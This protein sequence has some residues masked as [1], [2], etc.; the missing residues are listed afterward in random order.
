MQ[1]GWVVPNISHLTFGGKENTSHLTF[2]GKENT[3]SFSTRI[4]LVALTLDLVFDLNGATVI[5]PLDMIGMRV[6]HVW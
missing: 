6:L 4:W 5:K 2:G 1:D 3:L